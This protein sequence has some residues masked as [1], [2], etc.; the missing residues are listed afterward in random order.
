[1]ADFQGLVP[2][3]ESEGVM[4]VAGSVDSLEKATETTDKLRV[5]FP[6][7]YNMDAEKI[8]SMTGAYY[9]ET[10]KYL[11]ATGFVLRPDQRIEVACYSTGAIG[12][13]AAKDVLSLIRY[14]KSRQ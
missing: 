7:A 8:S 13:L 3:F 2:E 11:H 6:V 1:L 10:R 9:D 12:R 14:Y 5:T 4:I